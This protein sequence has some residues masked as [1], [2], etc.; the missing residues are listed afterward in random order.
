M[1]EAQKYFDLGYLTTVDGKFVQYDDYFYEWAQL[2]WYR[3]MTLKEKPSD[4]FITAHLKWSSAFRNADVSGCG[5]VFA[6]QDNDDHYA[7]FLDR[8]EVLFLNA[9]QTKNYSTRVNVTRGTGR[10]KF[11]NPADQAVEADFTVIVKGAYAY[12]LVDGEVVGE[13]T[14]SKSKVLHGNLGLTTFSG[15]NKDFGTRCE[16]TNIHSWIPKK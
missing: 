14:L 13:Y 11:N 3:W 1:A 16:M 4:F 8:R 15:T 12:V 5:F 10:V 9:D 6:I 2:G 7:V